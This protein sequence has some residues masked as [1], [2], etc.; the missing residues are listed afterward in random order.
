[1]KGQIIIPVVVGIGMLLGGAGFLW[2]E[3]GKTSAKAEQVREEQIA[4]V[5]SLREQVRIER[6]TDIQR[7]Q[8]S[9]TNIEN[10][11]NSL[12]RIETKLNK[13]VDFVSL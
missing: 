6:T 2:R 13:L 10:I 7:I 1:M 4:N 9:E 5:Q 11:Y 8:K 3:I 12:N